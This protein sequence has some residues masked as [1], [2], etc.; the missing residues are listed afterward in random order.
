MATKEW[1]VIWNKGRGAIVEDLDGN[2]YLDLT[3]GFVVTNAGHCHPKI[4]E[5]VKEQA[6]MLLYAKGHAPHPKRAEV[7]EALARSFPGGEEALFQFAVGGAEA[8]QAAIK[9]ARYLTGRSTILAFG[10]SYHGKTGVALDVTGRSSYKGGQP[11]AAGVHFLPYPDLFRSPL[12]G[13]PSGAEYVKFYDNL[14]S[15]P[16]SGVSDVAA[17]ILEP[18]QGAEGIIIPPD[19]FL[20]ALRELC[21]RHGVLLIADEIQ[22]GF[23]RTGRQFAVDHWGVVP[24]LI[25][26]GKG[27]A[28]GLPL[29]G[30]L[31]K[32]SL[33]KD[34]P[35]AFQTSTFAGNPLG[36]AAVLATLEVYEAEGLYEHSTQMGEKLLSGLKGFADSSSSIGDVR[37]KGLLIGIDFVDAKGSTQPN[38]NAA[39]RLAAALL[40]RG[41][42]MDVVGRYSNVA[43]IRPPLVIE[44]KHIDWLFTQL[45]EVLIEP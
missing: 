40:K 24:D 15:D 1:P 14:L 36:W 2:T 35:A 42:L 37:G 3:S 28:G 29:S 22:T 33:L 12:P 38:S 16:S 45:E 27:I 32:K 20:P 43:V 8:I 21:D 26:V 23:G 19:D 41:V 6:G 7:A 5:A 13:N 39:I 44:E 4:V 9:F 11:P 25:T 30:V 18:I 34:L 10:G 31:G 17:L